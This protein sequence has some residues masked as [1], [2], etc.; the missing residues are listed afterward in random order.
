MNSI[1]LRNSQFSLK[2]TFYTKNK[3]L[4]KNKN[5]NLDLLNIELTTKHLQKSN[6][7]QT[8]YFFVIVI[9][10]SENTHMMQEQI[11]FDPLI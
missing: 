10:K 2:H 9:Q 1:N 8:L 5:I 7:F 4:Q 6:V 11:V 3:H